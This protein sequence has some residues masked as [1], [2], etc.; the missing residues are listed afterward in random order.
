MTLK[1][2]KSKYDEQRKCFTEDGELLIAAS[3]KSKSKIRLRKNDHFFV[4]LNSG[5]IS[6][7]GWVEEISEEISLEEL[8]EMVNKCPGKKLIGETDE[9]IRD[10]IDLTINSLKN[11]KPGSAVVCDFKERNFMDKT[12]IQTVHK[13]FL[14]G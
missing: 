13:V 4:G 5:K 12:L 3:P 9:E 8:V 6:L 10:Q 11:I 1:I 2:I 14:R 7:Y